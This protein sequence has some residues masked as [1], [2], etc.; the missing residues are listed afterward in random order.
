MSCVSTL[1]SNEL[2]DQNVIGLKPWGF[3]IMNMGKCNV[4]VATGRLKWYSE[5]QEKMNMGEFIM[6]YTNHKQ[7]KWGGYHVAKNTGA[8]N[9]LFYIPLY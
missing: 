4:K 1:C 6:K 8:Y 2:E 5:K 9:K 3:R 7:P